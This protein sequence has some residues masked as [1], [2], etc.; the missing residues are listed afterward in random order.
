MPGS[1]Q[2]EIDEADRGRAEVARMLEVEPTAEGRAKEQQK[3]SDTF[4]TLRSFGYGRGGYDVT[5]AESV[6]KLRADV[7]QVL[8]E[9]VNRGVEIAALKKQI[10][11]RAGHI[12][13][14]VTLERELRVRTQEM[15]REVISWPLPGGHT[16]GSYALPMFMTEDA[17]DVLAGRKKRDRLA[18]A[19][20]ED[21]VETLPPRAEA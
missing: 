3:V 1:H 4:S 17:L 21:G 18:E 5:V 19:M 13:E 9:L 2:P 20:R 10:A 6:A 11:E 12:S 7:S 15:L 8:D 14:V 16:V